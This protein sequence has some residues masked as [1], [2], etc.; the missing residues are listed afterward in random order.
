[1]IAITVI[2]CIYA[3]DRGSVFAVITAVIV[4]G[5]YVGLL[6]GRI[7]EKKLRLPRMAGIIAYVLGAAVLLSAGYCWE[8]LPR[9]L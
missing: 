5:I 7:S 8:M 9:R 2:F 4:L 3:A 6:V 1:M